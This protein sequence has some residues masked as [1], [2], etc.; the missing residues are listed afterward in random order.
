MEGKIFF[1][2]L[3]D[4]SISQGYI[5]EGQI[6]QKFLGKFQKKPEKQLPTSL[7]ERG[8]ATEGR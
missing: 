5:A 8:P 3:S 4:L 6:L 7:R 2:K 1:L